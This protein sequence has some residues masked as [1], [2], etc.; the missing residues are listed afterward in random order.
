MPKR[1]GRK[2]AAQTPAPQSDRIYGS[3]KNAPK[4]A[5]SE[6]SASSIS[7]SSKITKYSFR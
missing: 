3:S 4:S 5:S 2:S 7:L 6:A 1:P